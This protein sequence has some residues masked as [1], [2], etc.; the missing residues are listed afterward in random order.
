MLHRVP[1]LHFKLYKHCAR[2]LLG[3]IKFLLKHKKSL[4]KLALYSVKPHLDFFDFLCFLR[5]VENFSKE[6]LLLARVLYEIYQKQ[7]Q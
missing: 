7:S 1:R 4:S 2:N 5:I 6:Y 3:F